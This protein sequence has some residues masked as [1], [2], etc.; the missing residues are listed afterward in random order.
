MQTSP[1]PNRWR[2]SGKED[3]SAAL[4]D[5]VL[6]FGARMYS[7]TG[8]MW[9]TQDPLAEK[10]YG[11]SPY[12]YCIGSP[13]SRY[14][15]GGYK[16]FFAPGVSD[17]FKQ[18]FA[19]TISYMN[20]RGTSDYIA[21]LEQSNLNYYIDESSSLLSVH[22]NPNSQTIYW[23]PS[24]L[25]QTSSGLWMSPATMLDHEAAHAVRYDRYKN[26]NASAHEK[27]N[28][29]ISKRKN[30]SPDYGTVDEQIVIEQREQTTARK[31]KE[32]S[33]HQVTRT[34]HGIHQ[35]NGSVLGFDLLEIEAIIREHNEYYG[36]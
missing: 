4:G 6:D 13:V 29:V 36:E 15:G 22:F 14:D 20:K 35:V 3:L 23:D 24:H 16:V 32:I 28:Y 7:S 12:V 19:E 33:V 5:P 26:D 11:V 9:Q 30:S 21:I 27:Q 34:D 2:F 8:A 31:H 18:K 25:G 17:E 10:Y 1:A